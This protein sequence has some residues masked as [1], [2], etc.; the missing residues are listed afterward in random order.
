MESF[1]LYVTGISRFNGYLPFKHAFPNGECL[2]ALFVF[3]VFLC[4]CLC[5][6]AFCL[7]EVSATGIELT[8]PFAHVAQPLGDEVT[9]A[10]GVIP[11]ALDNEHA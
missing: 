6:F 7:M 11:S 2:S 8:Q 3:P 9:D 5:F 1:S 10:F 4:F